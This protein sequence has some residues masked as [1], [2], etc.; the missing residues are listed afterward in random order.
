M[1]S[2]PAIDGF[3]ESQRRLLTLLLEQKQGQSAD[4]LSRALGISRSAVHQHLAA[5]EAGGF[6]EKTSLAPKGGRPGFS[7]RLTGRGVHLFPKQYA[8]F[9]TLLI[10]GIRQ[11]L[12]SEGLRRTMRSLGRALGEQNRPRVREDA[13]ASKVE[14]VA[15]IMGEL[16]YRARTEPEPGRELPLIDARNCIYHDLAREH[17]EVCELDLALLEMLLDCDVEH[18]ECMVR[19]GVACRFRM[20]PRKRG[21]E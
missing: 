3:G 17:G 5:L 8:L 2:T 19:G 10:A 12:G 21:E 11:Q 13:P 14:T 20:H 1:S 15:A 4:E 6:V 18:V 7:W 16:G 9:S